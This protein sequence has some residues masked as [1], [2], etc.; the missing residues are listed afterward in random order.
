MPAIESIDVNSIPLEELDVSRPD[1]FHT[2]TWHPWF[3]RLRKEAPVHYLADSVN[4]PFWSVTTHSLIKEVDSNNTVFSLMM[5]SPA[6]LMP[7]T[8]MMCQ[9]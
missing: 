1:L 8:T 7:V 6:G 4:G 9:Q 2:D 5:S 3:A